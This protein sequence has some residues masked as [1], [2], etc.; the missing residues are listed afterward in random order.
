MKHYYQDSDPPQE[1][2]EHLV[3]IYSY[4][5]IQCKLIEG[6]LVTAPGPPRSIRVASP[7]VRGII[8]AGRASYR[9]QEK[10]SLLNI[11]FFLH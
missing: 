9:A 10:L 7:T 3:L 4:S 2:I 1:I 8:Q 11:S 5:S 6:L